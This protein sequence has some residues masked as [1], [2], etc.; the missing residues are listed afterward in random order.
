MRF[1]HPYLVLE[2]TSEELGELG[3]RALVD[4]LA[5]RDVDTIAQ[6]MALEHMVADRELAQE[7]G[8]ILEQRR[9]PLPVWLDHADDVEL[10][11]M[12]VIETGNGESRS[13]LCRID[14]FGSDP[15]RLNIEVDVIS[16]MVVTDGECIPAGQMM[17]PDARALTPAELHRDLAELL[18]AGRHRV[19]L[20][21]T[22]GWP[23]WEGA[24]RWL[25]A[26]LPKP[27]KPQEVDL[28]LQVEEFVAQGHDEGLTRKLVRL[29]SSYHHKN[30]LLWGPRRASVML[31]MLPRK[32]MVSPEVLV[33]L[34]ELLIAWIRH[35]ATLYP[36]D[37]GWV[38]LAIESV[39]R[40]AEE[41]RAHV[42][43]EDGE[44]YVWRP[45]L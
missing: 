44:P 3:A 20:P 2:A 39:E 12:W 31:D 24:I 5:D 27:A 36:Q 13:Y 35:S 1:S 14:F 32:T 42:R 41:F 28:D 18:H 6:L 34:P 19:P 37:A 4:R 25:T 10:S 16:G 45:M 15:M 17:N 30:P 8:R 22:D 23:K 29:A 38:D 43:G 21:R 9:R 7:I 40:E 11:E 26:H 33:E